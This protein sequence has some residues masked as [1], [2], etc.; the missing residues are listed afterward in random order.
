MTRLIIRE[1]T[2]R[3]IGAISRLLVQLYAHE[4]PRMLQGERD[5][6]VE[7]GRVV[8][9]SGPQG[10]RYVLEADGEIRGMGSLATSE[11][12]KPQTPVRALL[13]AATTLG[14]R[15]GARSLVGIS[16][17]LLTAAPPPAPDEAQLH[18]VVVEE[19]SRA[20]GFGSAILA[21]LE[22]EAEARGKCQ[23]I[24]QVITSNLSAR[25]FYASAGY[26]ETPV[27]LGS[28]RNAIAYPSVIMRKHLDVNRPS[29]HPERVESAG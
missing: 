2:T 22:N 6:H 25:S 21:R 18:S 3:D 4:L 8:L 20:N 7:L 1:A 28:L 17:G 24:L 29:G 15:N 14:A 11:E 13:R 19:R 9:T 27:R 16:R 23:A 12:P 10:V 26:T 5:A